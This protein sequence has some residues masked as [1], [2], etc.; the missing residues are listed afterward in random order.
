MNDGGKISVVGF[1]QNLH[2]RMHT[3]T[4]LMHHIWGTLFPEMF[5]APKL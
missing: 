5:F 2:V 1:N 4:Q 3:R